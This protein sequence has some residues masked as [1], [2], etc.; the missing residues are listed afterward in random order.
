MRWLKGLAITIVGLFIL[1]PTL[2]FLLVGT[3]TGSKW[4]VDYALKLN[5]EQSDVRVVYQSFDGRLLDGLQLGDITVETPAIT[6]ELATAELNW[7]P[8]A[9]LDNQIAID[10]LTLTGLR[11]SPK[12]SSEIAQKQDEIELP[13][14]RLPFAVSIDEFR[15]T[16]ARLSGP[17]AEQPQLLVTELV[18]QLDWQDGRLEFNQLVLS[19]N[20]SFL[21]GN[22]QITTVQ[23]Y[24]FALQADYQWQ[25]KQDAVGINTINGTAEIEGALIATPIELS[26]E[27]SA[28]GMTPQ[29]LTATVTDPLSDLQWSANLQ[30]QKLPIQLFDDQVKRYAPQLQEF[31]NASTMLAGSVTVTTEVIELTELEFT[32]L[33]VKNGT[34]S[35]NGSWQHNNFSP[36]YAS[37]DFDVIA[38]YSNLALAPFAE[39]LAANSVSIVKGKAE[40]NGT[41][42]RYQFAIENQISYQMPEADVDASAQLTTLDASGSGTLQ[43]ITLEK[44]EATSNDFEFAATASVAWQP[45][46]AMRLDISSGT[47]LIADNDQ[48]SAIEVAGGLL[49]TGEEI[50]ADNLTLGVGKSRVVLNG[51]TAGDKQLSGQL[52]VDELQELPG[53]PAELTELERLTLNFDLSADDQLENFQILISELEIATES[54]DSWSITAPRAV[55]IKQLASHWQIQSET[56]CLSHDQGRLGSFCQTLTSDQEHLFLELKG[57]ELSLRLLNRF[58][59][60]DVAQR[61]SGRIQLQAEAKL[62]RDSF[63]LVDFSTTLS[64]SDTVFFAL[65]QETS[66][67]LE[68]WELEAKGDANA[69]N[70]T[71]TGTLTDNQGGLIGD[72]GLSELYGEQNIEGSLIFLLDDLAMLD[73]VIP[74]LRYEGGKATAS[75]TLNGTLAKPQLQ[76][77]ME[78]FAE[79]VGFAQTNL[80]FKEVRLALIDNPETE[81][82]LE[83]R[84]QARSGDKGWLLIE[85]VAMPLEQEAYLAIEGQNFR[86][87]QLPTATVDISPDLRIFSKISLSI[88]PAPSTC[89][90]P[91][92]PRLS[93]IMR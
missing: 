16:E 43:E 3:T 81:E 90:L 36:D 31:I 91:R 23:D 70:A 58:R 27:F 13:T 9:L 33:G 66:T 60:E 18:A 32:G 39:A 54:L 89:P 28:D 22:G 30:L 14:L 61:I 10:S 78:V 38:S 37:S 20:D 55:E 1:I 45:E 93:L 29:R 44:L 56:I 48:S 7:Q 69:I 84:G 75:L 59:E 82:E 83:I 6:I 87:L 49:V 19:Y 25:V 5:L 2:A 17:D 8:L 67:R 74:G 92:S 57:E 50:S 40:V 4:V 24:P 63:K 11:L 34:L 88:L 42:T 15:V 65:D 47:A 46:F 41:P 51:S 53:M 64:S 85:G 79:T 62:N 76:G 35:L 73:W 80:V 26:S 21:R 77:D 68:Y 72:F 71:L 86:A 12:P 52:V